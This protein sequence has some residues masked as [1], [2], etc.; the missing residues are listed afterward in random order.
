MGSGPESGL[1]L[2]RS[3]IQPAPVT[4]GSV[5]QGVVPSYRRGVN[6][7]IGCSRMLAEAVTWSFATGDLLRGLSLRLV[8]LA[9]DIAGG[10][11]GGGST[12]P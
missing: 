10:D 9:N 8:V 1:D 6:G 12:I 3:G 11:G 4:S 7:A 5:V 2:T